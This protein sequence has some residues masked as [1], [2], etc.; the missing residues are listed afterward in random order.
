MCAIWLTRRTPLTHRRNA[1]TTLQ[2]GHSG[3]VCNAQGMGRVFD[4]CVRNG[5]VGFDDV[6]DVAGMRGRRIVKLV[7]TKFATLRRHQQLIYRGACHSNAGA[8][9]QSQTLVPRVVR[10]Q[11]APW[12][13]ASP[14]HWKLHSHC[15]A[16]GQ[17][18]DSIR[19]G[20]ATHIA[21][22][23]H[24]TLNELIGGLFPRARLAWRYRPLLAANE[25]DCAL[26]T[27]KSMSSIGEGL[28]TWKAHPSVNATTP[29]MW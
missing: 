12:A 25:Q 3:E 5:I 14:H 20:K 1:H 23:N 2:T 13:L 21:T 19:A 8:T 10:W 15:I 6:G 7:Q 4:P 28:G 16:A 29:P 27:P 17:I 11:S 24:S 26:S 9:N 18:Y 22:Y